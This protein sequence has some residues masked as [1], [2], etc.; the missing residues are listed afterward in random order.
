[1]RAGLVVVFLVRLE[2]IVKVSF[3]KHNDVVKTFPPIDPMSRSAHPFCHGE[4][5]P[6]RPRRELTT[7]RLFYSFNF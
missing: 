3:A 7:H 5:H 2:Q 6:A 4:R 1:M